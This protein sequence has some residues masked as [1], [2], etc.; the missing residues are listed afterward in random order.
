L[1]SIIAVQPARRDKAGAI[2]DFKK[3][4]ELNP[5]LPSTRQL[6]RQLGVTL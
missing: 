1:P 2:A 5:E 4:L 3:A 6:L